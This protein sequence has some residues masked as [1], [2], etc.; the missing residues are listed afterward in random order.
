MRALLPLL[1]APLILALALLSCA[2]LVAATAAGHRPTL[3]LYCKCTCLTPSSPPSLPPTSNSTI[4]ALPPTSNSCADCTRQFCLD[5][6]LPFCKTARDTEVTTSCFARDGVKDRVVVWV[7]IVATVG[8]G[9][10]AGGRGWVMKTWGRRHAANAA[11]AAGYQAVPGPGAGQ[12][13]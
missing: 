3:Q 4:I 8:L 12:I 5:Y 6:N 1:L 7:F 11:A 2:P 9:C 10:W 13:R